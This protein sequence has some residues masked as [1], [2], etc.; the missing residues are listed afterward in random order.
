MQQSLR[1][2]WA[3]I[4]LLWLVGCIA[5]LVYAHSQNIPGAIAAAVLPAF[6]A[7]LTFY[8]ASVVEPSRRRFEAAASPAVRA[9]LMTAAAMLPWLLAG[10]RGRGDLLLLMSAAV[11]FWFIV[12]PKHRWADV[13]L[14]GLLASVLIAKP[15][16]AIYPRPYER[17]RIDALGQLM[18][19]RT[20]ILA[21]LSMRG[22]EG[23]G[24]GFLP[25]KREWWVGLRWF[26]LFLPV[27]GALNLVIRFAR[28]APP[29]LPWWQ[30]VLL[31]A[32]TFAGILWVV[33][34][35]E[36]FFVRGLLQQWLAQWTGSFVFALLAASTVFGLVHLWFR[37]FPNWRFALLAGTA[38]VFYG[39]AFREGRGIRAA[40]VTHACV[41]TA[42]RAFFQ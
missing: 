42:W 13:L 10:A 24:V 8:V 40:M 36:E 18:W 16:E 11:S 32:G 41:V 15:F 26:V 35:G 4:A 25:S 22:V 33:A 12:L 5:G 23:V 34:L 19:F 17:L 37:Q 28:Y 1:G 20:G 39:L 29:S 2:F 14:L 9:T 31:A 27:A 3:A 38:G 30:E 7:E 21:F 6:L